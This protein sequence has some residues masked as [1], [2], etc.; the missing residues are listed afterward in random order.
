MAWIKTR[1]YA[2]SEG[3]LRDLYDRISGPDHQI[4]KILQAHS[5]RPH[6]LAGHMD[7]RFPYKANLLLIK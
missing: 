7:L 6:T 3:E 2:G 4:D 5:L 1:D